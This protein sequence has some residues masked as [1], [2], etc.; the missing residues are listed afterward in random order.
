MNR[1]TFA[2]SLGTLVG[3]GAAIGT[4]A[5]SSVTA[6]R[7][8]DVVVSG[9]AGAYLGLQSHPGPNGAYADTTPQDT[10]AVDLTGSNS[11]IGNGIAGGEGLNANGVSLFLNVFRA[12]N[13]GTQE[14]EVDIDPLV[15]VETEGSPIPNSVLAVA[16]VPAIN[17]PIALSPGDSQSFH[18]LAFSAEADGEPDVSVNEQI[19]ITA[20][21]A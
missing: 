9:D 18:L 8:F 5:F 14:I 1:R 4:G 20:E 3:G 17:S 16:I 21:E 11:N 10:L 13:Q 12:T 15:F 2:V 19:G 6:E 7:D